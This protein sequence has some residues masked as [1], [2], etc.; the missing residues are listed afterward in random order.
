MSLSLR[1]AGLLAGLCLIAACAT[2]PP[3]I[4]AAVAQE[5]APQADMKSKNFHSLG[6]AFLTNDGALTI[7]DALN[8]P[9]TPREQ[10]ISDAFF[11]LPPIDDPHHPIV[12]AAACGGAG[13][14]ISRPY[15][16]IDPPD[17]AETLSAGIRCAVSYHPGTR[18][19]TVNLVTDDQ[20]YVAWF[21][22][23]HADGTESRA[24]VDVTAFA[25]SIA[26][27]P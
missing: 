10:R 5:P 14:D 25:D 13:D 4:E 27:T 19:H 12:K 9:T 6:A 21:T 18:W 26:P 23:V 3:K 17:P 8:R 11:K 7:T 2:Q 22:L 24:Y 20:R 1:G 15:T 16:P